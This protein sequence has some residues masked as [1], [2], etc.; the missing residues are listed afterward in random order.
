[1]FAAPAQKMCTA[2][3]LLAAAVLLV[4]APAATHAKHVHHRVHHRAAGDEAGAR[5]SCESYFDK[6]NVTIAYQRNGA[7]ECD[8]RRGFIVLCLFFVGR[9]EIYCADRQLAE[10]RLIA[11]CQSL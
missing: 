3:L 10:R 2:V 5:G 6:L 9:M 11:L 7:G 8:A 1:M 4:T